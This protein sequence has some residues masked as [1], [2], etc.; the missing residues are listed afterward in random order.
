[1]PRSGDFFRFFKTSQRKDLDI[2]CVN[3]ALFARKSNRGFS[4][5]RIAYGGVAAT[6]LRLKRV[7]TLLR[8]QVIAADLIERAIAQLAKDITPR[9]DLRGS[10]AYRLRVSQN[11]LRELLTEAAAHG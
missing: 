9:S 6:P 8:H 2:S 1:I 7:E 3:A 5:L 4:E 11:I 10:E